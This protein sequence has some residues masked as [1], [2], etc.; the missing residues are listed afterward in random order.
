MM[1]VGE[2]EEQGEAGMRKTSSLQSWSFPFSLSFC[3]LDFCGQ[4]LMKSKGTHRAR[5]KLERSLE[6]HA[7]MAGTSNF[8]QREAAGSQILTQADNNEKAPAS[9]AGTNT[10]KSGGQ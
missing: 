3:E 8:R 2:E 5:F 7:E 9:R 4:S 10:N 1:V 6:T